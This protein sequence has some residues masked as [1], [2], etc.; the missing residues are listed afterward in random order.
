VN[1]VPFDPEESAA[2]L[3]AVQSAFAATVFESMALSSDNFNLVPDTGG[4]PVALL[5]ASLGAATASGRWQSEAAARSFAAA[6]PAS[7]PLLPVD[8]L[9][10]TYEHDQLEGYWHNADRLGAPANGVRF[11]LYEVDP[12][13]EDPGT[14]E[15]GY[16]DLMDEST[17]L[18]YI[19]RVVAVT[20][21]VER[22]NYTVSAVI[23]NQTLSFNISGFI[24]DGTDQVDVDLSLSFTD[25][26]P[27][28]SATVDYLISVPT[29]DFDVDATVVLTFNN[30]TLQGSIAID[31]SFMQGA[32]TVTVS[33]L[34]E[35][36]EGDVPTEG[37][38]VEIH[39]DGQLFAV[40]TVSNETITVQ[41]GTGGALTSVEADAVRSIFDGLDSLFE[42]RFEDFVRPVGWMF[43]AQ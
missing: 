30:E 32:H 14:T 42:D 7:G 18:A 17:T 39:V 21:G 34:V 24:S 10:R 40:V 29:R 33:A 36:G 43:D 20:G 11:I 16:V 4:V 35:F 3:Q 15:I 8:F 25:T 19:A 13:T 22:I 38:T 37:G 28:S 27:V 6:G 31:G 26:F 41:N 12:I 9:G 5:Q 23:A 1:D 2:D